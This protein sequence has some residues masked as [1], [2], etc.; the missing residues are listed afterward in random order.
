MA[1]SRTPSKP[2]CCTR[3]TIGYIGVFKIAIASKPAPTESRAIQNT[4][5][6]RLLHPEQPL[7]TSA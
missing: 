6:T 7:A 1:I 4:I 5:K 3:T 2:A